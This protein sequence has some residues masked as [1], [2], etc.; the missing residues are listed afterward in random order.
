MSAV[1]V[2]LQEKLAR[3]TDTSAILFSP[4]ELRAILNELNGKRPT[5]QDLAPEIAGMVR[6][7]V[8]AL[9]QA[10]MDEEEGGCLTSYGRDMVKKALADSLPLRKRLA[11]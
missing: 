7:M 11:I 8:A 9:E 4:K 5:L 10:E 1:A 6:S 2:E 3:H